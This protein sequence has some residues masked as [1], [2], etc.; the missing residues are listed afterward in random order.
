MSPVSGSEALSM[1]WRNVPLLAGQTVSCFGVSLDGKA[2]ACCQALAP[3]VSEAERQRAARYCHAI[4]AARHLLGRLVVRQ[5]L[6]RALGM[7]RLEGE[8]PLSAKGKPFLPGSGID[9]SISHSGR[10]VWAA[11][12]REAVVGIDVE[13]V[14]QL[15]DLAELVGA[16]HPAESASI[17][18]KAEDA[19]VAFFRCWTRKEAVLKAGGEGLLRAPDSFQ[20]RTDAA[21][22]D[23]LVETWQGRINE[24]TTLDVAVSG[25]PSCQVAL[26]AHAPGL[27]VASVVLELPVFRN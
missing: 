25:D 7:E 19:N 2:E 20:V 16:L 10:W 12:C 11:F 3:F 21:P 23:W 13:E 15:E 18:E 4:D 27:Q 24:W 9:F 1:I 14:R 6:A 8:F 5:V 26:A 17:R 22:G